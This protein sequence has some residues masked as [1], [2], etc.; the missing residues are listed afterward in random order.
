[1]I[2]KVSY[3]F[4]II[5]VLPLIYLLARGFQHLYLDLKTNKPKV[6][7]D[8]LVKQKEQLLLL[9]LGNTAAKDSCKTL[10]A[11]T[12]LKDPK[13]LEIF[14]GL[15]WGEG[16]FQREVI[17]K[18]KKDFDTQCDFF[19]VTNSLKFLIKNEILLAFKELPDY[20]KI[21]DLTSI[22]SLYKNSTNSKS[23]NEALLFQI[24][25]KKLSGKKF[26]GDLIKLISSDKD[27]LNEL[28]LYLKVIKRV[29][30]VPP[31]KSKTDLKGALKIMG[32]KESSSKREIKKRYRDL[33]LAQHPDTLVDFDVSDNLLKQAGENFSRINSAYKILLKNIS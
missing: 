15:Q 1:M 26:D 9:T 2:F 23:L 8:D 29:K 32:L 24:N 6:D 33:A 13:I 17:S 10:L 30:E 16:P 11:Y 5:F 27:I 18:L 7:F 19:L 31:L 14:K 21:I 22:V 3:L 20:L 28:N 25:G 12:E 4:N